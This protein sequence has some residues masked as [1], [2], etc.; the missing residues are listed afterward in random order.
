MFQY[1]SNPIEL[2]K[3]TMGM[4]KTGYDPMNCD[5]MC[6]LSKINDFLS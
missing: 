5:K 2:T 6:M 1:A 3:D 4:E